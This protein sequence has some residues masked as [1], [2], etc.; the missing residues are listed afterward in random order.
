MMV[1]LMIKDSLLMEVTFYFYKGKL[2]ESSIGYY[3]GEYK[4]NKK[5]GKGTY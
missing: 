1:I 4:N 2:V 3:V 5:H